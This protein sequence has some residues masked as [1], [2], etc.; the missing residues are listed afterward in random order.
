MQTT[1]GN[2]HGMADN[3]ESQDRTVSAPGEGVGGWLL[4]L[5]ITLTILNPFVGAHNLLSH[6]Q[7]ASADF[8]YVQGLQNYLFVNTGLRLLLVIFGMHA[9]IGLWTERPHAVRTAKRY[10]FCFLGALALGVA[11]LFVMVEWPDY[12]R[13]ILAREIAKEVIPSLVFFTVCYLYLSKSKRVKATY[14]D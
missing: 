7:R 13:E 6:Y 14:M 9:G 3:L 8:D 1:T 2:A 4:L 11:L 12:A 10:L 5:C